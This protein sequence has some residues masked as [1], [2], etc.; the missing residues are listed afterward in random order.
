M[1]LVT[2]PL[3]QVSVMNMINL[4]PSRSCTTKEQDQTDGVCVCVWCWCWKELKIA[5]SYFPLLEVSLDTTQ[6]TL[7]HFGMWF[8]CMFFQCNDV[9]SPLQH[10]SKKS[11][12]HFRKTVDLCLN[13]HKTKHNETNSQFRDP[14]FQ[15]TR[16]FDPFV[17]QSAAFLRILLPFPSM[18]DC[19]KLCF[20]G[21]NLQL[22]FRTVYSQLF[23]LRV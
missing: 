20:H 23:L 19:P 10:L 16:Q 18:W 3:H 15:S 17:S 7:F 4:D 8:G 13:A 22:P 11:C 2:N 9:P 5:S 14:S 6:L 1:S 21:T 12:Q